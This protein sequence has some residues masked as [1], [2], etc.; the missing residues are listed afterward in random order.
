[1][2]MTERPI[3]FSGSMVRALLSGQ[4]T[5]TRRICKPQPAS[6]FQSVSGAWVDMRES[7]IAAI[8]CPYGEP[9][10]RLW[11][12]ETWTTSDKVLPWIEDP[13]IYGADLNENGVTKWAA[14]WKPSIHMP[15][16]A[17]RIT[18]EVTDIC[19]ERLQDISTEDARAE[20]Y[21]T[22]EGPR[23]WFSRI[24]DEIN[25]RDDEKSSNVSWSANPWVWV[26]EF[27]R[28]EP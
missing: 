20:G 26:V 8:R 1:M 24:W 2:G 3:L 23:P 15:R 19:I 12:R 22:M 9:G 11:V 16:A 17:S 4:K 28:I 7:G 18:L 6:P 5:Q 25:A 10:D 27:R 21:S 13:F 14:R